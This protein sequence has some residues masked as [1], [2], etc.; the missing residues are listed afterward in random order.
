M[1]PVDVQQRRGPQPVD[2][3]MQATQI[4]AQQLIGERL[5]TL[6]MQNV[7]LQA[8]NEI[9]TKE[10][11]RLKQVIAALEKPAVEKK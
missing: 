6:E 11:E 9:S 8:S 5:A 2:Q 3:T 4:R 7:F 10:I 1:Q